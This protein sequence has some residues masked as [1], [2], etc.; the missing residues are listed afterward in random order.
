MDEWGQVVI[1][2][3]LTRYARTQFLDPNAAPE[4][5]EEKTEQEDE[6]NDE[7]EDFDA[8]FGMGDKGGGY[9]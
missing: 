2:N 7:D 9:R 1:I 5:S 3:M 8:K 6:E 4:T